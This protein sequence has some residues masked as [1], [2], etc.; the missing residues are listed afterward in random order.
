MRLSFTATRL[1][2]F[3]IHLGWHYRVSLSREVTK[4]L[5]HELL[6]FI[7]LGV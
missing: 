3:R 2:V 1:L 4:S 6:V 5:L 7:I